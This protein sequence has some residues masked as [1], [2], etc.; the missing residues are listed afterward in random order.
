MGAVTAVTDGM[1]GFVE[2]FLQVSAFHA[3]NT[4][5]ETPR[6]LGSKG[7]SPSNIYHVR[8]ESLN[9][10]C[11]NRWPPSPS[12]QV[13]SEGLKSGLVS[14]DTPSIAALLR[15]CAAAGI[16][17]AGL[18]KAK[19]PKAPKKSVG[20]GGRK[21]PAAEGKKSS[22]AS[23]ANAAP[24]AAAGA[25]SAGG[26]KK[27]APATSGASAN[28]DAGSKGAVKVEEKPHNA[29]KSEAAKGAPKTPA[30]AKSS[31]RSA[32]RSPS[33]TVGKPGLAVPSTLFPEL[34]RMIDDGGEPLLWGDVMWRQGCYGLGCV[35]VCGGMGCRKRTHNAV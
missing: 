24:G 3:C 29:T 17:T 10:N 12:L 13:I 1:V 2:L 32:T 20:D 7:A 19:I 28:G 6:H 33:K 11:G 9:R 30:G 15:A 21:S 34:A 23:G 31:S 18:P 25:T 4:S 22:A 8:F 35:C 27:K 14:L 5:F 16:G 26:D